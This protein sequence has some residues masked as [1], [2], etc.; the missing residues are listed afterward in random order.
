MK[1]VLVFG[2]FDIFHP[3]HEHFLSQAKKHGDELIV[4]VA[5]DSTVK[6]V[7][8]EL[9]V[10]DENY[11]LST[12]EKLDYVDKAM[13]GHVTEDKYKIIEGIKPDMICLGYDQLAFV[14]GLEKE[15]KKRGLTTSI[16]RIDAY[17]PNIYKS[18][19]YKK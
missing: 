4:V 2:T 3:G 10:R 14:D 15:L 9:P 8:G 18:S 17:K 19:H 5:R 6:Q 1:R 7:K 11:R 12:I 16:T 13:L